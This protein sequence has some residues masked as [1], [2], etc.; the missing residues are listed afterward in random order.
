MTLE[1]KLKSLPTS[2]GIYLHKNLSGRI[3]YV[4]KAL[5][6]RS[7]VSSYFGSSADRKAQMVAHD[8]TKVD[9]IVT[10]SELEA[11]ILEANLIKR[12]KPRFNVVLKDDKSYP[13]LKLTNEEY[14]MIIFTRRVVKDLPSR[15]R[16]TS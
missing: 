4:G 10:K 2:A 9:F 7:R 3:I 14:P 16:S 8:S 1:E 5:S 11:L 15:M 13:F 12:Y 6:L